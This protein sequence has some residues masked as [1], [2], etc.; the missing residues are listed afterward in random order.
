MYDQLSTK[1]IELSFTD[2]YFIFCLYLLP[3]YCLGL[4]NQGWFF[5]GWSDYSIFTFAC[6]MLLF[7]YPQNSFTGKIPGILFL[8]L[9]CCFIGIQVLFSLSVFDIPFTEVATVLRK[10]IF[11]P[12]VCL[13]ILHAAGSRS[14][15][16]LNK[17][18]KVLFV[19]LL[20][21]LVQFNI[22]ALWG[23]DLCITPRPSGK[24]L[25]NFTVES[26]MA[27]MNIFPNQ[28]SFFLIFILVLLFSKLTTLNILIC[29]LLVVL[30]LFTGIR[31]FT[32]KFLFQ[33]LFITGLIFVGFGIGIFN[34]NTMKKIGM[35][36][37][38]LAILYGLIMLIAHN[39]IDRVLVRWNFDQF[40]TTEIEE[41]SSFKFR[42]HLF[43][44]AEKEIGYK[45]GYGKIFGKGYTKDQ[46]L[47]VGRPMYSIVLGMD[48]MSAGILYC[49][50][51]FGIALRIMPYLM[52]LLWSLNNM[53]RADV[54]SN[55][56]PLIYDDYC[57][58]KKLISMIC[59]VVITGEVLC[60]AFT[61]ALSY[62]QY[63]YGMLG[64]L[65]IYCRKLDAQQQGNN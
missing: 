14:A 17:I 47:I 60:Y 43:E 50:G 6:S 53:F 13:A 24:D 32:I 42:Q 31:N 55:R 63:I 59:I 44:V 61:S 56:P 34:A 36:L 22:S 10:N 8:K 37:S 51:Y 30:H 23:T 5:W 52:L 40:N 48:N 18:F 21:N 45:G 7:L 39:Q 33:V 1:K 49:E 3:S 12:F 29:T 35:L 65:I 15:E 41:H 4:L 27:N 62:M 58:N 11:Q 9:I 46:Y 2:Y 28:A 54:D 20:I 64:L 19:L 26:I 25:E 38:L 57:P 16:K